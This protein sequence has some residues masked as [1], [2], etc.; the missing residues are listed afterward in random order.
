MGAVTGFIS[1]AITAMATGVEQS[2]WIDI[3]VAGAVGG[4]IAGAGI[5]LSL[6]TAGTLPLIAAGIA[7]ALGGVGN[8]VT[9]MMSCNITN[10]KITNHQILGSLIIGG[11]FNVFS[12]GTSFDCA[13]DTILGICI[14][15]MNSYD[16]NFYTGLFIAANTSIAT[17]NGTREQ[18]DTLTHSSKKQKAKE[19]RDIY[20][21]LKRGISK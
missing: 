12:F 2:Q 8:L 3:A 13:S 15:G 19:R 11:V 17:E 14:N 6:L 1:G 7:F 16:S 4:A 5:D 21:A 18:T 10:E 20:Y 9:T